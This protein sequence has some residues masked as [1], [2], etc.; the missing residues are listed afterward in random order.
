M[1]DEN[2]NLIGILRTIDQAVSDHPERRGDVAAALP[3]YE[4]AEAVGW[5]EPFQ[6]W[7]TDRTPSEIE[8]PPVEGALEEM[9]GETPAGAPEPDEDEIE[10]PIPRMKRQSSPGSRRLQA[11]V[12]L[13]AARPDRFGTDGSDAVAVVNALTPL[14][15]GRSSDQAEDLLRQGSE[16]MPVSSSFRGSLL[17][18]S[19]GGDHNLGP[20]PVLQTQS[21]PIPGHWIQEVEELLEPRRWR[22]LNSELWEDMSPVD[23]STENLLNDVRRCYKE[24][25]AVTS[26]FKLRPVLEV[27]SRFLASDPPA[28]S[29]EYRLCTHPVH[30]IGADGAPHSDSLVTV[31]E[32]AIVNR[33]LGAPDGSLTVTTTKRVAFD[34]PFGGAVLVMVA[35][36]LGYQDAFEDM[37]EAA[38]ALTRQTQA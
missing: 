5:F 36:A 6:R 31:D 27:F 30:S 24:V 9:A 33:E 22:D 12:G 7:V 34:E 23:G 17:L 18:M 3:G 11:L 2:H 10:L 19:I 29:L 8:F 35:H 13:A 4:D 32:G 38:L 14:T 37:V 15:P 28:R 26:S 16:G 1:S 20:V 25:F 21:H